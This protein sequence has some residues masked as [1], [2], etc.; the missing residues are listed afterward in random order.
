MR[1]VF[2]YSLESGKATQITDGMSDAR[3]PVFDT[4]GKYLYF[5]AST[6]VGL[7]VGGCDLSGTNHPVD[8]QRLC[9]RCCAN[10]LPSP[11]APESDEEKA[12]EK[13][14]GD[15]KAE[16][17]GKTDEKPDEKDAKADEKPDDKK[18]KKAPVVGADGPGGDRAAGAGDA[19]P[20]AQLRRPAGGQDRDPL[21]AGGAGRGRWTRRS[22][23]KFTL[24]KFD[25]SKRKTEKIAGRR[26]GRSGGGERREADGAARESSWVIAPTAAPPKPG[27]GAL[28]LADME[29]YV[30]PGPSGSRCT[31][32]CGASSET[33]STTRTLHGLDLETPRS[34]TTSRTWTSMRSRGDLN[35][36]F[37][38][39]LG[40]H[41]LRPHVR[42]RRRL[43]RT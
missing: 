13:K 12:D 42:L 10:D 1:A 41:D 43:A 40:E 31:A 25:L 18:P 34:A 11:L 5:A 2:V 32:R 19:D 8:P 14:E 30:D 33:S 29:V 22:G 39:M 7:R 24:Q 23:A 35:Y 15:A 20:G 21:P 9:R 3:P 16:S 4:N 27:E 28:K 37:E 17:A 38:E 26:R 6:D 36:L